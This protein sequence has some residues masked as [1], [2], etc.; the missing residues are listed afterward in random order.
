MMIWNVKF[1]TRCHLLSCGSA[2]IYNCFL[3]P[4]FIHRK[5]HVQMCIKL[6]FI[7][8][9]PTNCYKNTETFI[10][11]STFTSS[12]FESLKLEVNWIFITNCGRNIPNLH[13]YPFKYDFIKNVVG[14][15]VAREWETEWRRE[16]ERFVLQFIAYHS[17]L[18]LRVNS[19]LI[20]QSGANK[21]KSLWEK[22]IVPTLPQTFNQM[23]CV[24]CIF[25]HWSRLYK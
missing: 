20:N 11:H 17:S 25:P 2:L 13:F 5:R 4:V 6:R 16:R 18:G 22:I 1:G 24:K 10:L 3:L 7:C 15:T 23:K 21:S 12:C 19:L 14:W 8:G 9:N